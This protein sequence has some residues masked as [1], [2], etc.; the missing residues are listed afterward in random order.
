MSE[1]RW[2][3]AGP[4][5]DTRLR[6]EDDT[7]LEAKALLKKAAELLAKTEGYDATV[8]TVIQAI[9]ELGD[10]DGEEATEFGE[11]LRS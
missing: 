10:D 5:E 9:Y 3:D 8:D 2:N 11:I 4:D 1:M 7:R 6:A